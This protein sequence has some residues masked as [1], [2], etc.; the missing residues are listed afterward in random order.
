MG[1]WT[2]QTD[3]GGTMDCYFC[4][5]CGTRV[6]HVRRGGKAVSVKGGC[7]EGLDWEGAKHIFVR[8]AVVPIPEEAEKWE[9]DPDFK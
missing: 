6:A 7:I 3:S 4:K 2:R 9:A 8:S 1:V 5:V